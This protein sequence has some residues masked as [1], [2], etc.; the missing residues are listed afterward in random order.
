MSRRGG[1]AC[2]PRGAATTTGFPGRRSSGGG[3]VSLGAKLNIWIRGF[4]V[5]SP[6]HSEMFHYLKRLVVSFNGRMV[7]SELVKYGPPLPSVVSP[8]LVTLVEHC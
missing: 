2:F 6:C 4:S 1:P 7:R 3:S 5:C 8:C